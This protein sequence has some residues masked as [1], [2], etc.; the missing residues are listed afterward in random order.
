MGNFYS[1]HQPT[2]KNIPLYTHL[3]QREN[4]VDLKK[5]HKYKLT[6]GEYEYEGMFWNYID[7]F[8]EETE[9]HNYCDA[10]FYNYKYRRSLRSDKYF[11]Y[12]RFVSTK[13]YLQKRRV[14]YNENVLKTILKRLINED[15]VW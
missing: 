6:F 7:R 9:Y 12:Y 15:F 14:K 3:L 5:G 13:E 4:F 10:M 11:Q 8:G 1:K 2:S